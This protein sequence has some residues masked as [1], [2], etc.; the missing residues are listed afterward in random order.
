MR[1][2]KHLA[3]LT[4]VIVPVLTMAQQQRPP[5]TPAVGAPPPPTEGSSEGVPYKLFQFHCTG[6]HGKMAEAPT[7]DILKKLTPEKIYEVMTTGVMKSQAANL[8]D[9]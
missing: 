4:L 2:L 6:C 8:K 7:V 9:D 1:I 5:A 3:I